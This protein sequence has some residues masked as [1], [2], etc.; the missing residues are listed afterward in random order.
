[1]NEINCLKYSLVRHSL[2]RN[3][4]VFLGL[5]FILPS[6]I[7]ANAENINSSTE[8]NVYPSSTA[9]QAEFSNNKSNGDL[10]KIVRFGKEGRK[11]QA[12][13]QVTSVSQLSDVKPTDWAFTSLQSLVERYGCIAGY[14]DSTYRGSRSL[15]RYEFAA[16]LNACLNKVNELVTSGLSD[17]VGKEDL[18]TLQK[19]Q[20]EFAAELSALKG[21]VGT[22]ESKVE[23]L[24][25]KQFSTTTKLGILGFFNLTGATAGNGVK[26]QS[27][28]DGSTRIASNPNTTFSGLVWLDFKTSFTGSDLLITQLAA[29]NGTSPA[30]NYIDPGFATGFFNSAGTPFT[31]Q[32]AG[33]SSNIFVLRELS[34]QFPIFDKATI[35]VGP[36]VNFYKYFDNNRFTLFLN[37]TSSF[38]SIDST[39]LTNAKRGAG[40]ILL[41]PLGGQLD[42]KIGYLAESNEF[43]PGDS[44]NTAANP[45]KGLFG[46]NNAL[47][48]ELTYKPSRDINLRLL[49][50]RTNSDNVFGCVGG[51]GAT[52]SLPG[53]SC[54]LDR[55]N[56]GTLANGQA[57]V[58]GVNFDWLVA[59]GFGL[60]GRYTVSFTNLN[61]SLLGRSIGGVTTQAFQ[62][63]AAFPDLFKQ[64]AQGTISFVMP[65]NFTSGRNLL[66]TG[67]G[68]GGT[69]YE[70]E[71]AYFL[72]LTKNVSLV[73]ALYFIFNPNNFSSN[74]T[75]TVA[76]LR[77]QFGF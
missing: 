15:T 25:A 18:A 13:A 58:V 29:G 43:L 3:V 76:N 20:E 26:Y 19:L 63:G 64:G 4:F 39:L 35:V 40:A 32:T 42:F 12:I 49:Y 62:I 33:T 24:E 23:T 77:L 59:R 75:I 71:T 34:Y 44:F 51:V 61:S 66:T 68:D 16:G 14:P 54:A 7:S 56:N 8:S 2:I 73:P 45:R 52:P 57:D 22:L 6:N 11:S 48:A 27:V 50:S 46:G 36:R 69:Q 72:P 67:S 17:K 10:E 70:L 37:G 55:N 5:C 1:M 30:N 38:N 60:F 47:T 41:A 21:R 9:S 28:A 31:D 65:W 74:P 53:T